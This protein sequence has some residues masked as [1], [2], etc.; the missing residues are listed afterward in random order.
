MELKT[1]WTGSGLQTIGSNGSQGVIM[2]SGDGLA[3]SPMQMVLFGLIG[4]T[5]MD[6]I[7][8]IKKKRQELKEFEIV[9]T[10]VERADNHPKVYTRLHLEYHIAGDVTENSAKRAVMLSQD[11]YC[12]VSAMLKS[13]A[14]ITYSIILNDV[15]I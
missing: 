2:D 13:T 1:T 7:S 12:S 3:P 15:E 10:K 11:S 6:A 14:K 9:L 4:C 5:A 8:I